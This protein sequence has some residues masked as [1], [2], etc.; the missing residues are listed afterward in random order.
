MAK[1]NKL[2]NKLR[3]DELL[4]HQYDTIFKTHAQDSIIEQLP[5]IQE[6]DGSH[7]LP[8]RGVIKLTDRPPN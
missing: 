4:F 6:Q 3:R 7:I 5:R 8:Y 2:R 1:L